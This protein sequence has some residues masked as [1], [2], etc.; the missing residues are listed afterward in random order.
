MNNPYRPPTDSEPEQPDDSP[1]QSNRI[2]AAWGLFSMACIGSNS[3]VVPDGIF[4]ELVSIGLVG[5]GLFAGVL[6]V[7]SHVKLYKNSHENDAD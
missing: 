1:E 7:H 6:S 2:W 5:V 4:T 3:L